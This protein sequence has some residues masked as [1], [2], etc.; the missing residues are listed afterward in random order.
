MNLNMLV[1]Q[2][3]DSMT[4]PGG[5]H[6]RQMAHHITQIFMVLLPK[7]DINGSSKIVI[8]LGPRGDEDLFDNVLG[9][10]NIF[11][12][13]FDFAG[14]LSLNRTDQDIKLLEEL[15]RSLITIATRHGENK[16]VVEIINSTADAVLHSDFKLTT[17]IKNLSKTNSSKKQRINVF[18]LLSAEVGESWHCEV[19]SQQNNTKNEIHM[20]EVPS[21]IDRSDLFKSA[22]INED[23]Y[24]VK[25]RLGKVV[26]EMQL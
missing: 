3:S 24:R 13:D 18:R 8:E 15:R 11:V 20:N 5:V 16:N 2:E 1:L 14:L 26:F 25:N 22:E 12:E 19:T 9:V 23:T 4:L 6:I 7:V 21:F 17:P 10:T